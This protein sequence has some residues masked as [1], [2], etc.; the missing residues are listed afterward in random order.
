MH[1]DRE[2]LLGRDLRE[3][4]IRG[5][6]LVWLCCGCTSAATELVVVVGTDIPTPAEMDTVLFS[7][8]GPSGR[9]MQVGQTVTRAPAGTEW[10]RPAGSARSRSASRVR[11]G[12]YERVG[13]TRRVTLGR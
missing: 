12:Q 4:M 6:T 3:L 1:A 8:T 11:Y 5:C 2:P 7:V 9:T 10:S 13:E